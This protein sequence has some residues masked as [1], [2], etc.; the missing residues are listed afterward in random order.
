MT[1]NNCEFIRRELDELMLDETC[2]A[3][4]VE[5][6]KDCS[7]CREFYETRTKLRQMVGSLGTVAAPPDF[8]YR[9]RARLANGSS[10]EGFHYWTVARKGLA[11]AAVLV[12]FLTGI[13]VVRNIVNQQTTREVAETKPTV[14]QPSPQLVAPVAPDAAN[15]SRDLTAGIQVSTPVRNKTER[16][17]VTGQRVKRPLA[18]LESA[19]TGAQVISGSNA[20]DLGTTA[21]IPIDASLPSLKFSLDDGS[22]N[23]RTISVPAIRFGSQRMLPNGNQFAQ[24]GVW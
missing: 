11:F 14:P 18:T 15:T 13:I 5:H 4:A 21:V 9:L 7:A 20:V 2:S 22:G 6:L 10:S 24:K 23:A 3:S 16:S 8:E 17:M 19:S 12:V 1:K